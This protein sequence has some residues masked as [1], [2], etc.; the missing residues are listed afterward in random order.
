VITDHYGYTMAALSQDGA[1]F[2]A[3]PDATDEDTNNTNT[4][5]TNTDGLNDFLANKNLPG[6]V[7]YYH[8]F[9]NS[10]KL[11]GLTGA[12]Y[13]DSFQFTL[14]YQEAV[15][16]VACGSGW[17][18][19]STNTNYM[20][21]FTTTG[22]QLS[23]LKLKGDIVS[24]VGEGTK[25]AIAYHRGVPMHDTPNLAVDIYNISN[26]DIS[27]TTSTTAANGASVGIS[28]LLYQQDVVLPLTKGSTL[29]W[30]GFDV[31]EGYEDSNPSDHMNMLVVMDS[32]ECVS[33]LVH[34]SRLTTHPM[35][36][37]TIP[38][39]NTRVND[40]SWSPVLDVSRCKKSFDHHYW[41]VAIKGFRLLY[42]LLHGEAK[43]AVHP[44]PIVGTQQYKLP[45][46]ELRSDNANTNTKDKEKNNYNESV[47]SVMLDHMKYVNIEH[48]KYDIED[49]IL[50][51]T[52]TNGAASEAALSLLDA[53]EAKCKWSV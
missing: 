2:A 21:I 39:A 32:S 17:V 43:P 50:C 47:R 33:V 34:T 1:V 42:V 25:L 36:N 26:N 28:S 11:T 20:R 15:T 9:P 29:T 18:A 3:P 6:S 45:I 48:C 53:T 5:N 8:A 12:T 46:I 13:N 30:M 52:N 7:V 10:M 38:T 37:T 24:M 41:P 4:N 27:A 51:S 19:I 44:Q 49:S 31:T 40:F 22:I 23:I 35:T 16:A 14:S